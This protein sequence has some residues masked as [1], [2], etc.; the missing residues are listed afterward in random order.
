MSS[1]SL[2]HW[3]VADGLYR[4]DFEPQ[5]FKPKP[6][7]ELIEKTHQCDIKTRNIKELIF[8]NALNQHQI[9][10]SSI[11]TPIVTS[12]LIPSAEIYGREEGEKIVWIKNIEIEPTLFKECVYHATHP[13]SMKIQF[14]VGEKGLDIQITFEKEFILWQ[15]FSITF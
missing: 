6:S 4:L 14:Q 3:N 11:Q 10:I 1:S 9:L 7:Y 2:F 15:S 13:N 5:V 8:R 12:L